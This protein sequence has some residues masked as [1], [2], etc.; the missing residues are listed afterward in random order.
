MK[1]YVARK[2]DR[3]YAVIYEGMDPLTGKERRRWHP[4]GADRPPP[5]SS[6]P[7]SPIEFETEITREAVSPW[8]C[9]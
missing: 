1:G 4:A 8:R 7:H 3:Y 5:R 6:Q 2:G 9:T